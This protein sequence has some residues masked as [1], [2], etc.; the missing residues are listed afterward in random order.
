MFAYYYLERKN[1]IYTK[2]EYFVSIISVFSRHGARYECGGS[3]IYHVTLGDMKRELVEILYI[4]GFK[5]MFEH[6]V[7]M[8]F[9]KHRALRGAEWFDYDNLP[10]GIQIVNPLPVSSLS[11]AD[12]YELEATEL[13]RYS[14]DN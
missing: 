9:F 14:T 4:M 12:Q 6:E 5:E 3:G 2:L 13:E 10:H 8:H 7:K 11:W 1:G